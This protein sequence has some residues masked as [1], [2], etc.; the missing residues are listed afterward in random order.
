[1]RALAKS[2]ACQLDLPFEFCIDV[3]TENDSH[4]TT[5]KANEKIIGFMSALKTRLPNAKIDWGIGRAARNENHDDFMRGFKDA[6]TGIEPQEVGVDYMIGFKE[7]FSEF[8]FISRRINGVITYA[9]AQRKGAFF[10]SKFTAIKAWRYRF[11]EVPLTEKEFF[12]EAMHNQRLVYSVDDGKSWWSSKQQALDVKYDYRNPMLNRERFIK[13]DPEEDA[14]IK[15]EIPRI[16]RKDVDGYIECSI[17]SGESYFSGG[18]M[19]YPLIPKI[20][21]SWEDIGMNGKHQYHSVKNT[22][23]PEQLKYGS[24]TELID[25]TSR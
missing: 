22:A 21:H 13:I 7:K 14:L 18:I 17:D 4:F 15:P 11:C 6:E 25:S 12:I 19:S 16:Y 23:H 5:A 24:L 10:N 9:I 3:D 20:S 8:E 2:S 1:M